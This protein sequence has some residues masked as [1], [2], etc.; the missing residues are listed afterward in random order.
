MGCLRCSRNYEAIERFGHFPERNN[1]MGR[2]TTEAELQFLQDHE[3]QSPPK[4]KHVTVSST[5][6]SARDSLWS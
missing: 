6:V 2:K 4:H 1:I 5:P 3:P